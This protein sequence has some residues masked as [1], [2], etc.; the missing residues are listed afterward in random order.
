METKISLTTDGEKSKKA[1]KVA[2]SA[3]TGVLATKLMGDTF[4]HGSEECNSTFVETRE[5]YGDADTFHSKTYK[6]E[7]S[8]DHNWYGFDSYSSSTNLIPNGELLI[9]LFTFV[10]ASL[11]TYKIIEM[12]TGIKSKL[13]II[14]KKKLEPPKRLKVRKN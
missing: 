9:L 10:A 6:E 1:T 2:V 12:A 8:Y 7:C 3:S 14:F 11:L 5:G 13:L 4:T